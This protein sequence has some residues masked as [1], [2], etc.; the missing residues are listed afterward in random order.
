MKLA[1]NLEDLNVLTKQITE[2]KLDKEIDSL[3][4]RLRQK[5]EERLDVEKRI[6]KKH[7]KVEGSG[8]IRPLFDEVHQLKALNT[9]LM[10]ENERTHAN[11]LEI[12]G[13]IAKIP[14]YKRVLKLI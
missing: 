5:R 11:L 2:L 3:H 6:E 12:Q 13:Q 4:E 9:D 8:L 10:A 14:H 1:S 7:K